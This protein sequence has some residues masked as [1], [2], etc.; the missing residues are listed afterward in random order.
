MLS[1]LHIICTL[2]KLMLIFL[3][4]FENK[5]PKLAGLRQDDIFCSFSSSYFPTIFFLILFPTAVAV[6]NYW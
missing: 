5:L 1:D 6:I 4:K 2:W 3:G